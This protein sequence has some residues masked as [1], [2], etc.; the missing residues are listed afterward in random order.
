MDQRRR[1]LEEQLSTLE[2][3][4]NSSNVDMDR[5]KRQMISQQE[6]DESAICRLNDELAAFRQNTKETM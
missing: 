6:H 4:L 2:G 5:L 3:Q 1:L